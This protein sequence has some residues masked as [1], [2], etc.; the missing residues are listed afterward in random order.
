MIYAIHSTL[1]GIIAF[2]AAKNQVLMEIMLYDG[3]GNI[4]SVNYDLQKIE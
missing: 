4:D 1:N 2:L 3:R